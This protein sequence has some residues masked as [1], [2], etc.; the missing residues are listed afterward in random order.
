M[1]ANALLPAWLR[2]GALALVPAAAA[3][4]VGCVLILLV[5]REPLQALGS[6]LTGPLPQLR[7]SEDAGWTLRR[8]VRFGA[9]IEDAITLT[10]LGL[11]MLMGFRA[12]QFSM[13]ADGQFF[14]AALAAAV[15]SVQLEAAAGVPGALVL[16]LAALAAVATG[17]TWGLLPGLL[18]TRWQ[19]NEI[20]TSLMLNIIAIQF[21]RLAITRWFNDPLAGFLTTPA[22][23]AAAGLATLL[24]PTNITAFVLVA[25]LAAAA[26]WLL[27]ERSTLGYEIRAVGD[28]PA[29]AQHSGLPAR[30]A[31]VLAM[32][33]GGAFAGLA[34]LHLSNGLL[35]RLPAELNPGI[36]FEGLVVALLARNNPKAVPL[37]ALFYAYLKGGAEV[38]ER[39]SDVP[40][41]MVL[42]VQACIVLFVVSPRLLRWRSAGAQS[43]GVP[44]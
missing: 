8:V 34:G 24:P 33:L 32:A 39:S 17:F 29:F 18:K 30:R 19:A 6:L 43:A 13:G 22:L 38:M 42:V 10:L 23:G 37:A 9:V 31:V 4:A 16:P 7:W 25:P 44:R 27:L 2:R 28:S 40:R 26:A 21:Y 15:V 5:S 12:R 11:A 3:L 36:G 41:E 20:V 35:K 1:N 14:L